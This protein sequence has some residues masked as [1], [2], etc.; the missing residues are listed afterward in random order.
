M[1]KLAA[2]MAVTTILGAGAMA[3]CADEYKANDAGMKKEMP[4]DSTGKAYPADN[5]GINARDAND[6]AVT[7]G[8]Q[9]NAKVD[10]EITSN[11]RKAVVNDDTL[12]TNAKNVKIITQ[13][14]IVTLRG[15]VKSESE[16]AS[17]AAKAKNVAGVTRVN[18]QLEIEAK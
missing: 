17:V 11:I 3:A 9:S 4:A 18:N 6:A 15:P 1:K 10:V 5:S 16:R 2:A 8:D 7:A 13:G 14:G 12:S